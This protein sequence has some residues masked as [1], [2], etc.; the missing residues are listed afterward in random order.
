MADTGL[1]ITCSSLGQTYSPCWVQTQTM[2]WPKPRAHLQ[3][4]DVYK[5]V[6]EHLHICPTVFYL[7][8]YYQQ[9]L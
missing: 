1:Y 4:R 2:L 9:Q 5:L 6:V 3:T 7:I 8:Q